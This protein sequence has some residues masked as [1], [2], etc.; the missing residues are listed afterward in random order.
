MIRKTNKTDTSEYL[1]AVIPA[2]QDDE[3]IEL[4]CETVP[5]KDEY[6]AYEHM[7]N[8]MI[9]MIN[10]LE[11]LTDV[12]K[13]G[14]SV[15]Y[16]SLATGSLLNCTL[17]YIFQDEAR[18]EKIEEA[19]EQIN[20]S[21]TFH[22][23][24]SNGAAITQMIVDDETMLTTSIGD[25]KTRM[26]EELE[27]ARSYEPGVSDY[28]FD[29]MYGTITFLPLALMCKRLTQDWLCTIS[30]MMHTKKPFKPEQKKSEKKTSYTTYDI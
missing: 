4:E 26:L 20:T 12:N 14:K 29:V 15:F 5:N 24:E 1:P 17:T 11:F 16:S 6:S 10:E 19:L 27:K 8:H 22:Y 18:E 21:D 13:V 7:G 30:D 2:A 3:I 9:D 28:A 23:A 25:E